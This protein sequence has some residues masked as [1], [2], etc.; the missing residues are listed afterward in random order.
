MYYRSHIYCMMSVHHNCVVRE[1]M[2]KIY[3]QS[4][5]YVSYIQSTETLCAVSDYPRLCYRVCLTPL[6]VDSSLP[7][8]RDISCN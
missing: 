4:C 5:F 6:F 7:L 3:I 1:I 2:E 8:G